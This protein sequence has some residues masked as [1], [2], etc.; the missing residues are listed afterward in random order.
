MTPRK[1]AKKTAKR[2]AKK[3]SKRRAKRAAPRAALAL[4]YQPLRAFQ[5]GAGWVLTCAA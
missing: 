1:S 5:N 2:T 3:T 4:S